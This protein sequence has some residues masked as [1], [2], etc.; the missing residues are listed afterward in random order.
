MLC[1]QVDIVSKLY[2]LSRKIS[3]SRTVEKGDKALE[4]ITVC[5]GEFGSGC[6]IPGGIGAAVPCLLIG[7]GGIGELV[8]GGIVTKIQQS[9]LAC[10]PHQR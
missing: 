4:I 5:Q 3:G 8:L 6:R 9:T 1:P 10:A 2:G 7:V